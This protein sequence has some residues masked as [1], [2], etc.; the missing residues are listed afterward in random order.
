M[1]SSEICKSEDNDIPDDMMSMSKFSVSS[2]PY[3]FEEKYDNYINSHYNADRPNP[4]THQPRIQISHQDD[5]LKSTTKDYL[6]EKIPASEFVNNLKKQGI[7][8]ESAPVKKLLND[9]LAGSPMR[10]TRFY[11]IIGAH[12]HDRTYLSP[13][14]R[15]YPKGRN[16]LGE[17][18]FGK[19]K[20]YHDRILLSEDRS[21][22][23]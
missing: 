8:T 6:D 2:V 19:D 16:Y 22:K 14:V 18:F 15:S 11:K 3:S 12:K 23:M 5:D 10:Y 20:P 7:N 13:Q 9:N 21:Q 1:I 17:E 4:I